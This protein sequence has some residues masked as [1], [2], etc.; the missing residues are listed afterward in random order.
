MT[1][2]DLDE[3]APG[4][5]PPFDGPLVAVAPRARAGVPPARGWG[6]GPAARACFAWCFAGE[7]AF[8]LRGV[9][10]PRA[11]AAGRSPR[12]VRARRAVEA[13]LAVALVVSVVDLARSRRG[14]PWEPG[15]EG[16][17]SERRPWQGLGS[18]LDRRGDGSIRSIPVDLASDP[19]FALRLLP[20]VGRTKAEAIVLDRA[21][22]GPLRSLEALARVPGFGLKSVSA[23]ATAGAFVGPEATASGP[24]ADS[25]SRPP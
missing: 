24:P 5:R 19:A 23:L 12:E 4:P 9:L 1:N 18:P 13:L 7:S 3:P 2:P 20:G 16:L 10:S 25:S 17:G 21:R 22:S 14:D 6:L 15:S 11:A 8:G